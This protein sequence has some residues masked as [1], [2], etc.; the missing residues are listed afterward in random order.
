M[1]DYYE[2]AAEQGHPYAQLL[3]GHR[4]YKESAFT[5]AAEYFQK[6]AEQGL[7]QG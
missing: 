6:A 4:A 1:D 5:R 7:A 3:A 2:Q